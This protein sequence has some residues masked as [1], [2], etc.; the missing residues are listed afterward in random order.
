MKNNN[1]RKHPRISICRLVKISFSTAPN[2]AALTHIVDLSES[3]LRFHV[4][5]LSDSGFQMSVP[6][7]DSGTASGKMLAHI[8]AGDV[9]LFRLK[10]DPEHPEISMLGKMAWIEREMTPAGHV[11]MRAGVEIMD[12]AENDRKM[13]Q[14]YVSAFHD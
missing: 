14:V 5:D 12:L 8:K 3:G 4:K 6:D 9:L 11:R 13:I 10:L 7:A 1:R 2:S